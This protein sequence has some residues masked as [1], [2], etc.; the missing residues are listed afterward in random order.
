[1]E[2]AAD[3][4]HRT[5]LGTSGARDV[6]DDPTGSGSPWHEHVAAFGDKPKEGLRFLTC[7]QGAY[8][9]PG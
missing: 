6:Y 7:L 1:M 5:S 8:N 3:A 9:A 2:R 4:A